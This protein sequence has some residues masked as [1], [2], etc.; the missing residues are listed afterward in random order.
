MNRTLNRLW[1]GIRRFWQDELGAVTVTNVFTAGVAERQFDIIA[2]ATADAAA[3][4]AHGLAIRGVGVDP[5][6]AP[7]VIL[8]TPL[9][10]A[11]Y[12]S[13]W[14]VNTTLTTD[15]TLSL[16]KLS[17]AASS[18]ATAQVRVTVLLPHSIIR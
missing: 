7:A 16:V 4:F 14:R 18:G 13:R 15:T 8:F 3:T 2:S 11:A 12:A 9:L 5:S 1:N 17:T 10:A 6:A